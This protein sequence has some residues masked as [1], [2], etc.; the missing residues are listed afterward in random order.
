MVSESYCYVKYCDF[1]GEVGSL[2]ITV[3]LSEGVMLVAWSTGATKCLLSFVPSQRGPLLGK[4][5]G[6]PVN[7][8]MTIAAIASPPV[9]LMGLQKTPPQ[10][11]GG[12]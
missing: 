5:L 9:V 4:R 11:F 8:M 2:D 10:S 12:D 6:I 1:A 3:G 7:V